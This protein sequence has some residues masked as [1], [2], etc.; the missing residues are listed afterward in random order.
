MY[1]NNIL[2]TLYGGKDVKSKRLNILIVYSAY[3]TRVSLL[4]TLY[5]FR[6]YTSHR[7]YYLNIAARGIPRYVCRLNFD[8]IVFH[9]LFF[10]KRFDRDQQSKLFDKAYCLREI[11]CRKVITPQ[12]EFINNDIV[13][14]FV[15]KIGAD[16]IFSVQPPSAWKT[17]YGA[18]DKVKVI[19]VLTGYLDTKRVQYCSRFLADNWRRNIW[20]GYRCNGKPTAWFGRHGYLKQLIAPVLECAFRDAGLRCDISTDNKDALAGLSWYDFLGNCRYVLG[21][22]GG[23]SI[24]DEKGAIKLATDEFTR[25]YPKASFE[26]I[27]A[28]CFP[29][30]DGSFSGFAIS[31][32]HLEACMTGTCQILTEGDY[33]GI[34]L[35]NTHYI[36]VAKDFKN[37]NDVVRLVK[38]DSDRSKIVINAYRDIVLSEKYDVKQFPATVIG[39]VSIYPTKQPAVGERLRMFASYWLLF[40]LDKIDRLIALCWVYMKAVRKR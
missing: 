30:V 15:K 13:C 12:D 6:D 21:V 31:P 23:T 35:P 2:T 16:T 28:A 39:D 29:G 3:T 40:V 14:D 10:S 33:N 20:V 26:E 11:P 24:F 4:D 5:S 8:L 34:L 19:N 7:I 38:S 32:R 17:V 27:E 22:E 18:L 25:R 1:L 37:V 9:S 36:P